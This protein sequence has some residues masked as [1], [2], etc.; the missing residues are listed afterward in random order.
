MRSKIVKKNSLQQE[1]KY[2]GG[3]KNSGK[4]EALVILRLSKIKKQA[5]LNVFTF[6]SKLL[7]LEL[8]FIFMVKECVNLK[9]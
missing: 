7:K 9:L 3:K 6:K 1:P 5:K 4:K 8:T 2:I